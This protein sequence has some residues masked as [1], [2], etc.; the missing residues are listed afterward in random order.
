MASIFKQQYTTK[1]V[2]GKKVK[3]KTTCWYIEYKD[4]T[5]KTKR[6]KGLVDKVATRQLADKLEREAALAKAGI[7]NKYAEHHKRPLLEHLQDFRTSLLGK[8][9]TEKQ[10]RQVYNR[11][12]A[13]VVSCKF[14]YIADISG[15]KVQKYLAE[16]RRGGLSIRTSNG[17]LQAIKQF[18]NWLAADNR[19]A[20]NP[21]AYLKGQNPKTDIRHPRRALSA[22]ELGR[23]ITATIKGRKHSGMTG[24]ERAMLY[25]L[26]VS[27]G[28]RAGE[29]ASLTWQSFNMSD[30]APSVTV[31]AAYSKRRR[32]G[33][34]PL[35][36]DIAKQL[37]VWKSEQV[38][39]EQSKVFP[40]INDKKAANMLKKDLK[41]AGIDYIDAAGR[42][43]DFHALR[44]SLA[45]LLNQSGVS[46]KVAQSLLRHSTIGLTMD[47]YTHIGLYDERN[48]IDSLP[49]LPSL[50]KDETDE[51]KA[52]SLKT[53]TDNL[54]V[55][56]DEKSY[57]KLTGETYF[58]RNKLASDGT[59]KQSENAESLALGGRDN[60]LT[61]RNIGND[62]HPLTS[63]KRRGRDSNPRY[64]RLPVR[65]F[66][67]PL[68]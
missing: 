41:V 18:A 36:L 25:T 30:S 24:K 29:L 6:V 68:P 15:S 52:A 20:E 8:G 26:A 31:L 48:A 35:R 55:S 64:G 42:Y 45:S 61:D 9:D 4:A 44:H 32:E 60:T 2:H 33:V 51:K 62:C 22:E 5:G 40:T 58:D 56:S 57:R 1:D 16:R 46:P 53:G 7:V 3:R 59:P 21:L 23:L 50:D 19:T 12:K 27:T 66:S 39:G 17:Y 34:Q 67:K 63:E 47:T 37:R 10:A 65:R 43:A 49:K 11:A 38:T 14:V 13:V 28:F 54:P